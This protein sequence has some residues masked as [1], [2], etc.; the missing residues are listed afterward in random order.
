MNPIDLLIARLAQAHAAKAVDKLT[1]RAVDLNAELEN[2]QCAAKSSRDV[3]TGVRALFK[4]HPPAAVANIA[5]VRCFGNI[6]R[7]AR[8]IIRE[9]QVA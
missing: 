1:V 9:E 4:H 5:Q 6:A 7:V 2:L 8:R 3:E